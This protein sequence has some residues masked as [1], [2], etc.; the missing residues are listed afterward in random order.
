MSGILVWVDTVQGAALAASWE[1]LGVGRRLADQMKEP[2]TALVIGRDTGAAAQSSIHCG[3]DS[4]LQAD[5]LTLDPYRLE[6]YAALLEAAIAR[7]KP[8]FV[9]GPA[10]ARGRELLPYVAAGLG[11]ALLEDVTTLE[12]APERGSHDLIGTHPAYAGKVNASVRASG[13][14]QMALLRPRAF[15]EPVLDPTQSGTV[16][17]LSPVLTEDAIEAKVEASQ[18][19]TNTTSLTEARVIV[20]GG[21][22]VGGP[23]GFEPLRELADVLG[24]ALGASRATVDAG[25]IPY[26]H[27][28][29]Q[30]GKTVSPD[31]Y[32]A[33]GISGAIQ[34]QAGMR[35]SKVIVAI[36]KDPRA[37]IFQIAHYG[38]VADLASFI[39]ALTQ[40]AREKLRK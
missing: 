34:H 26:A 27:Q 29:G 32:I 10:S 9:L 8:R 40:A 35:T 39:P 28:V 3:A 31:L 30:T 7:E 12:L 36:N 22:G 6:P 18:A 11:G 17:L 5:D 23:A 14:L 16:M 4:V 2:L 19:L 33:V 1:A 13:T 38:V 20:S 37:P 25:W 21:R 15:A 24:G